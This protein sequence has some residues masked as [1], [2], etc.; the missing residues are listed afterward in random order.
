MAKAS[1][2]TSA[3]APYDTLILFEVCDIATSLTA[4]QHDAINAFLAAGNKIIIYD[5]DR[6]AVGEGGDADY[7]W[8]TY[9]FATSNPGPQGASGILDIV[10]NS[11]LTQG[12]A[13]DPFSNDELGDA[14]TATTADPHWYAAAKT[15]NALGNR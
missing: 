6:C 7:S 1:L 8:F 14:N 4:S 9:P 2:S 10:E 12:L 3:L 11:T 5:A 13:S 15:T